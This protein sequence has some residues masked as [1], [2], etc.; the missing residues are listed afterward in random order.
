MRLARVFAIVLLIASGL[1]IRGSSVRADNW[2]TWRGPTGNSVSHDT[3]LPLEWSEGGNNVR[4]TSLPEWGTST[5]AIW[6]DAVFLTTE[7]DGKLLLLK[8][9]KQT[10]ET[11]WT[12]Q[13]GT[14]TANRKPAGG[15]N[16]A[17]KFHDMHNLASPSPVTD[18]E[19]VIVHFGNGDLAS[20]TFD[21]KLEW[22]INLAEKFGKYTIWWGH[23]NSPIL[24]DDLVI[25]ACMQD[26]MAGQW[27][28]LSPSYIV[29]HDKRDGRLVWNTPRMTGGDAEQCDAY[30]TPVLHRSQERTELVVMGGNQLDAY[31]PADGRQLWSLGGLVGGRTI[32]G[33]TV[34]HGLVFATVGMR[35][36]LH[37]VKLGGNG[38]RK[39]DEAV[40][41]KETHN[42]PDTSCPVVSGDLLFMVSDNGIASCFDAKDGSEKWRK[43]I[44]GENHKASPLAADGRIYFLSRNGIC[45]VIRAAAEFELLAENRLDDEFMASPAISDGKIYLRGRKSLYTISK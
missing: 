16:R 23:A 26:S 6:K 25:S 29:A 33:P 14:G 11:Q 45:T 3:D 43:R 41:W 1:S 34:A 30:T 20:Y 19:R 35:G 2:P 5:P 44:G 10:G 9:D 32:T 8:I 12:R 18:G 4:K 24:Y 37:A 28:K 40:A 15:E 36:P 21:G 38:L 42:T 31:D 13:V 39:A 7:S 22:T 27:E 17:A